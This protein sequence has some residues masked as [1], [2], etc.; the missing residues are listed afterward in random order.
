MSDAARA[1]HWLI[2]RLNERVETIPELLNAYAAE[3]TSELRQALANLLA[4]FDSQEYR[5][6][7]TVAVVHG[8]ICPL[9]IAERNMGWITHARS[10]TEHRA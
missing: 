4:I 7:A 6:E 5:A 10:L 8:Q 1:H 3:Q 9:H 2:A